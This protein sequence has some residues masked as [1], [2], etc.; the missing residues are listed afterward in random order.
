MSGP[1]IAATTAITT[2]GLAAIE[3][4][5]GLN[6][7]LGVWGL[8]GCLWAFWYLPVMPLRQ[9]VTSVAIAALLA[10]VTAKPLA[11]IAISWA[12]GFFAWWP[13]SVDAKLAGVPIALVIGLLCHTVIGKKLIEIASRGADGV[14]KT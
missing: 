4:T 3:A 5:T 6:V 12:S 10:G 7:P 14:A 13:A 8:I 2:G 11:L 1:S 9:R